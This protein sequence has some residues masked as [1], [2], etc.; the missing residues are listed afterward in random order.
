MQVDLS[1]SVTLP[2]LPVYLCPTSFHEGFEVA[3]IT[4]I[5][6]ENKYF[7]PPTLTPDSSYGAAYS[8]VTQ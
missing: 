4:D 3:L 5:K 6:K 1:I 7:T 8:T 2:V